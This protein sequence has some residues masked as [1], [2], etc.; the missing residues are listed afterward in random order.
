MWGSGVFVGVSFAVLSKGRAPACQTFWDPTYTHS[1]TYKDRIHHVNTGGEVCVST[2]SAMSCIARSGS[3]RSLILLDL[4][5]YLYR[6]VLIHNGKIVPA[7]KYGEWACFTGQPHT[8]AQGNVASA[9]LNFGF[10]LFMPTPF[11][12][13]QPSLVW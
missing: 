10:P 8:S 6:C 7:N 9:F 12:I 13:K 4:L 5:T 3:P 1:L 11:G 2:G